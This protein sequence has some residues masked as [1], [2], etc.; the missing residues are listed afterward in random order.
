[1][2][3]LLEWLLGLDGIRLARDAPLVLTWDRHVPAWLLFCLAVAVVSSV[4]LVYAPERTSRVRRSVLVLVRCLLFALVVGIICRPSLVLLR[5][6][7]EP[8]HVALALDTSLSMAAKD[9]YGDASLAAAIARGVGVDDPTGLAE[10]SRCDLVTGALL[11]DGAAPLKQLLAR[12][13]VK[14][15]TFAGTIAPRGVT[16]SP[17]G[18]DGLVDSL[19]STVPDGSQTDLA[20]AVSGLLEDTHGRRLAAIVLATDGQATE[21]TSLTDALNLARDRKI[22]VYPLRIGSPVRPLDIEVGHL[23]AEA[24]VFADDLF[25]AEARV[26]AGGLTG[27]VSVTVNLVDEDTQ[28]IVAAR[29]VTLDPSWETVTVELLAK[30]RKGGYFRYRVEVPPLPNEQMIHNNA[31]TIEVTVIGEKLRV[32]YVDG[33]PR[34]EYRYLKNALIR[35]R[36]MELSVLLLSADE[37]FVQEGTEPIRR[38]PATAEELNRYDV[39][40]FGDVDPRGGWL[41]TAQMDMLLDFVRYGG[42]GFGIIAGERAAPQRLLGTPLEKL[43]PVRIDPQ[44]RGHYAE[45]LVGGF[46]LRITHEGR[47]SRLFRGY[48]SAP[49]APAAGDATLPSEP[50]ESDENVAHPFELLSEL[51]WIARTLG[52]KPGATVLAEHPTMQALGESSVVPTLMP[53][54]VVGRYGA[55]RILFQA[56]DDTWRW[57]RHTGEFLH[58][59]YWVQL[60]RELM[61]RERVAQNRSYTITTNRRA[62][63]YGSPVHARVEINDMKLLAGQDDSIELVVFDRSAAP[64]DSAIGSE[65]EA[66]DGAGNTSPR[67]S[68]AARVNAHRL[69]PDSSVFEATF[70]PAR[71][72]SFWI[73]AERLIPSLEE[74]AASVFIRVE[75]PDLEAR[76]PQADH[77]VL[78][79]IA[80]ATGGA[81]IELDQLEERFAEIRDRS[82]RIPDDLVEPLWDSRLALIFFGLLISGEWVLRKAFGL[83]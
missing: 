10:R 15:C 60:V 48:R 17:Q 75:Q 65:G 50:N 37:A 5:N 4:V 59:T 20:G 6:R 13:E 46:R 31:E 47:R 25:A 57:R 67:R 61:K 83:L 14:F 69:G 72:G 73:E 2:T 79:R 51:Y 52:P 70:I 77:E 30:P 41:T 28:R 78:E 58:D 55:G 19:G 38:F 63:S 68:M 1:M 45:A 71:P 76:S 18:I 53:V 21:P 66:I 56:T 43:V 12:N 33:Y 26:S 35:E 32:L 7:V 54:V 9:R 24:S 64:E 82:V 27:P 29:E 11:K 22:P 40:L 8:S 49:P 62:Y 39:V 23:R 36:S 3:R 44:F 16:R 34:Y 80:Q 81:V 42:G 74:K